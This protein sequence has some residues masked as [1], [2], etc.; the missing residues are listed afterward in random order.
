MQLAP[1]SVEIMKLSIKNLKTIPCCILYSLQMYC[2]YSTVYCMYLYV[3]RKLYAAYFTQP[4]HCV[5]GIL[6]RDQNI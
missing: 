5:Y 1:S 3:E 4:F 6:K 2:T